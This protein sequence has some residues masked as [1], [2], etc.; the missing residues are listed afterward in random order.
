MIAIRYC[1]RSMSSG[2]ANTDKSDKAGDETYGKT[3]GV[4][5]RAIA[6]RSLITRKCKQ[7]KITPKAMVAIIDS[8]NQT[9]WESHANEL[10]ITP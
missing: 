1:F 6:I 2:Q 7:K 8:G 9:C 10:V 4:V 5:E 3:R